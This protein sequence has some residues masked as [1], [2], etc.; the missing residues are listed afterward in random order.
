[1]LTGISFAPILAQMGEIKMGGFKLS[2]ILTSVFI[3][4]IANSAFTQ[5]TQ[6]AQPAAPSNQAAA[7]AAPT[8]P[9]TPVQSSLPPFC[10]TPGQ[11]NCIPYGYD[12][13]TKCSEAA[14]KY[15]DAD[16]RFKSDCAKAR[17]GGKTACISKS[18][19][20]YDKLSEGELNDDGFFEQ[21]GDEFSMLGNTYLDSLSNSC[22]TM[23]EDK[24]ESRL[25]K[26][27]AE[28]D[29]KSKEST[30]LQKE[31]AK[32]ED[33]L[34]TSL[35]KLNQ[36]I[37]DATEEMQKDNHKVD[38]DL[39]DQQAAMEKEVAEAEKLLLDADRHLV[40]AQGQKAMILQQRAS[41]LSELTNAL[42]AVDCEAQLRD[43]KATL[44]KATTKSGV[45]ATG[46]SQDFFQQ[47]GKQ[48]D[49]LKIKFN[50]CFK[51]AL[52][53]R[54]QLMIEFANKVADIDKDIE[55]TEV[56]MDKARK[57]IADMKLKTDEALKIAEQKKDE[58]QQNVLIKKQGL[59]MEMMGKQ[60]NFQKQ[61]G[62]VNN[63]LQKI[64]K[65]ENAAS[66]ELL[67]VK[68]AATGGSKTFDDAV[69]TA[70]EAASLSN[71]ACSACSG[72]PGDN[73]GF[74]PQRCE[75]LRNEY[76]SIDFGSDDSS[77]SR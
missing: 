60:Q 55:Q 70:G 46:S 35:S 30:D 38:E 13:K 72:L 24:K 42:I 15:A 53:K 11:T 56:S 21:A 28:L 29:K 62:I 3:L 10:L 4:V 26:I 32:Q 48:K 74:T 27:K 64:Q 47:S 67:K 9:A 68:N 76:K 51:A 5:T 34:N 8:Q 23:T 75:D 43:F 57:K 37:N 2:Q 12:P 73:F 19:D 40:Q 49:V 25:E 41:A 61:Q 69:A 65:D 58:N 63:R 39:R 14:Q 59:L 44:D 1:M 22:P 52:N 50:N 7:P 71:M 33:D 31:L 77:G 18:I 54:K 36:K 17:M 6:T 66:N 45:I 16:A 20:C